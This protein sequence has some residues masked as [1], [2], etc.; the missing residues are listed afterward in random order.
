MYDAYIKCYACVS[1]FVPVKMSSEGFVATLNLKINKYKYNGPNLIALFTLNV[2]F[3][4]IEHIDT[5]Y[6]PLM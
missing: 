6:Q 1:L 4:H 5:P 2:N 3:L